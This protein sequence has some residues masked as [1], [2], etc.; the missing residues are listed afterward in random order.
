[1]HKLIAKQAKINYTEIHSKPMNKGKQ[2]NHINGRNGVFEGCKIMIIPLTIKE[3]EREHTDH[4]IRTSNR[5]LIRE[6]TLN[7]NKYYGCQKMHKPECLTCLLLNQ[8]LLDKS[9]RKV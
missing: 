3:H 5:D 2:A 4:K 6:I 1:M 7:W 9:K 8:N